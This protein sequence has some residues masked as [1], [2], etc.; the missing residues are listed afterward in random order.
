MGTELIIVL[1]VGVIVL[2]LIIG[3]V[4]NDNAIANGEIVQRDKGFF[5]QSHIF[6]TGIHSVRDIYSAMDLSVFERKG[7]KCAVVSENKIRFQ[8]QVYGVSMTADLDFCGE[9]NGKNVF[10]YAVASYTERKGSDASLYDNIALTAVEKAIFK[11][12]SAASVERIN[13]VYKTKFF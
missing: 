11:L 12:D 1:C 8:K 3:K 6:T 7:M 10:R 2:G 4:K 9:M 5:K 13:G